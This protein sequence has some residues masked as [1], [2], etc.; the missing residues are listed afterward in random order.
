V[1]TKV[2]VSSLLIFGSDFLKKEKTYESSNKRG[3]NEYKHEGYEN[4]IS[5]EETVRRHVPFSPTSLYHNKAD[6]TRQHIVQ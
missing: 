3:V 2:F 1:S 5:F 6:K 4:K